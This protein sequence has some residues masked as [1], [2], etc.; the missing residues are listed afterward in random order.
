[1]ISRGALAL[2]RTRSRSLARCGATI[3]SV[4][5]T[6]SANEDSSSSNTVRKSYSPK[7]SDEAVYK[8]Y[9]VEPQARTKSSPT[10]SSFLSK[11]KEATK[12]DGSQG[13]QR[14]RLDNDKGNESASSMSS[15]FG[16]LKER[17][18][19]QN[20]ELQATSSEKTKPKSAFTVKYDHEYGRKRS[21]QDFRNNNSNRGSSSSGGDRSTSQSVRDAVRNSAAN[22]K[23]GGI[24]DSIKGVDPSVLGIA[25]Q[26]ADKYADVDDSINDPIQLKDIEQEKEGK[27]RHERHLDKMEF[28]RRDYH[29]KLPP[30]A[31]IGR[32][33]TKSPRITMN[34]SL[35][36]SDFKKAMSDRVKAVAGKTSGG[37]NISDTSGDTRRRDS[38]NDQKSVVKTIKISQTGVTIKELASKLSMKAKQLQRRLNDL[39]ENVTNES[40]DY[41]VDVDVAELA[42]LE[43]GVDVVREKSAEEKD[44]EML[45]KVKRDEAIDAIPRAPVV[46]IM[47]HVDHGK[48]TLLD[49]LRS[50]N[51]AGG[52]AG[53]ITQRLS[54][55]RVDMA[56]S[57]TVFLDTPGHAAFTAMRSN[58]ASATDLVVL[59]VAIEDGVRPQTLE[60]LK[61]A[62]DANSTIIIAL[63]KVD[64]IKDDKERKKKRGVVL[65]QL[66]EHDLITEDLGGDVQV[67]EVSGVTGFGV[68]ELIEGIQLQAD[69]LELKAAVDGPAEAVVLDAV[70][71]KGRGVVADV[72]VQWGALKVGDSVVVGTSHGKIRAITDDKGRTISVAT[73]STPIRILG[74]RSV[75][76]AGEEMIAVEN[77]VKAKAIVERREKVSTL[78][79]QL[80][81]DKEKSVEGGEEGDSIRDPIVL[82][83]ILKA[84]GVGTSEAL[85]NIVK[86]IDSRSTDVELKII[87]NTV[88][89]INSS[90]V[91]LAMGANDVIVLGF[92]IGIADA[93][94]RNQAKQNDIKIARDTVIYR[95]EDALVEKIVSLMPQE[96]R[97]TEEGHATVE[98]IFNLNNKAN[99]TVAG[100]MVQDGALK[101]GPG[102]IYTIKRK[103]EIT[104]ED[105][106]AMELRRFKDIVKEV[107]KGLE[108]GLTLEK[109]KDFEEG[110]EIFCYSFEWV[111]KKLA[112]EADQSR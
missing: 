95:L 35:S 1:M 11:L 56:G 55:F 86:G 88:G 49:K 92:N 58:G 83:V 17:V 75:P 30:G 7:A 31:D 103:G 23:R 81:R 38:K 85:E 26:F 110:D 98:K 18:A 109:L 82:N 104:H 59:V 90:D 100:L 68:P 41:L 61:I 66:A 112:L 108:C 8:K 28:K 74:L 60:A 15:L 36:M 76:T 14:R 33:V 69:M 97:I 20:E 106:T 5:S 40:D 72:L 64:K 47:G 43:L 37:S 62:K 21:F 67:I 27:H 44:A 84:D 22:L 73:P 96:K 78:K 70:M 80:Q 71:E 53:G 51:V 99:T 105:A 24:P 52:E 50:A 101:S 3:R 63:N 48:T 45:S 54:A 107:E 29:G 4:G 94:T 46:C 39:G 111:T 25:K 16:S 42:A 57:Q 12:S 93:A 13:H 87:G 34:E 6:T 19:V 65:G 77:E 2:P 32:D 79:T 91:E 102:Y 9:N 10:I 89:D